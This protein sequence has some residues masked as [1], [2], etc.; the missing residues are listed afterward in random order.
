MAK[1]L[2]FHNFVPFHLCI[3]KRV[4]TYTKQARN[5]IESSLVGILLRILSIVL[6]SLDVVVELSHD[7]A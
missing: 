3:Y 4:K 2:F 1:K 6:K 7:N 5:M